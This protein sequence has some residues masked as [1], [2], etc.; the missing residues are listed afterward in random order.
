MTH[1]FV[2]AST[3]RS[4]VISKIRSIISMHRYLIY[5][6]PYTVPRHASWNSDETRPK[7]LTTLAGLR[8][9]IVYDIRI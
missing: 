6:W 9:L 7:P 1:M 2:V 8:I 5:P 4:S 3:V